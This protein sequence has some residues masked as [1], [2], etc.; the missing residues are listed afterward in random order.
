MD[1]LNI[2]NSLKIK[3]SFSKEQ[4]SYKENETIIEDEI[5]NPYL[6]IDDVPK[7]EII[8]ENQ[9]IYEGNNYKIDEY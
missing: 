5:K 4:A 6:K 3:D 2:N 9:M 7:I 8:S 1:I